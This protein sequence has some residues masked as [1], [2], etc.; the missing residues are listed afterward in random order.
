VFRVG[1]NADE[2]LPS[3]M[4][5]QHAPS[6]QSDVRDVAVTSAV[7]RRLGLATVHLQPRSAIGEIDELA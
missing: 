4:D 1:L 5:A 6:W 3:A 2:V 7:K